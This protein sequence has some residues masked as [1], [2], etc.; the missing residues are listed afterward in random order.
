MK[1]VLI[2]L[3]FVISALT[4]F[5]QQE[6]N[7]HPDGSRLEALKI[8]YLTKKL[9]LTPVE[10]QRFWPLYN[11]YS[12]EMRELRMSQRK[13]KVSE[14]DKEEK[15][16]E[17]RKKY[18]AEFSNVLSADKVDTFFRSEKEF[19]NYVQK[20]LVERRKSQHEQSPDKK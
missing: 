19:R 1:K 5:S 7:T 6:E 2:A 13:A 12:A 14:L 20:E 15:N 3:F 18:S 9:D 8:A 4:G 16:L 17:L 11:N 10:A